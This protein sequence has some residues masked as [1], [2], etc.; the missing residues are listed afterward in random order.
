MKLRQLFVAA[1]MLISTAVMVAQEGMQLPWTN[2]L[3]SS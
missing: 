1:L 3:H 2:L